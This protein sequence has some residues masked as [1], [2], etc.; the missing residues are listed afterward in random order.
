M[1]E[2]NKERE[3]FLSERKK[4]ENEWVALRR[5]QE[6][7]R[8]A[9]QAS[10]PLFWYRPRSDGGYEG[11]LHNDSIERCRKESG[12][13]VPL[14]AT[15]P[16]DHSEDACHMVT[17]A[18]AGALTDEQRAK[19]VQ[20]I[21]EMGTGLVTPLFAIVEAIERAVI[22]VQPAAPAH[23]LQRFAPSSRHEDGMA[24]DDQGDYVLFADVAAPAATQCGWQLVPVHPTKEMREAGAKINGQGWDFA[25]HTW[26]TMLLHAP[27]HPAATLAESRQGLSEREAFEAWVVG[28]GG[29]ITRAG[30]HDDRYAYPQTATL[31]HGWKAR[32]SSSRAEVSVKTMV[33]RFLGWKLPRDFSPDCGISFTPPTNPEW[34]PIGTSLFHADQ[35]RQMF[36]YVLAGQTAEPAIPDTEPMYK[37]LMESRLALLAV[38][39]G[40]SQKAIALIDAVL[41]AAPLA[42]AEAPK[43]EG[44]E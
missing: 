34:W 35:A 13:W 44:N 41:N 20:E 21:C 42:A 10:G 31:W 29:N 27:T 15:P 43:Q 11:P 5:L 33:D 7:A 32:A 36:E 4:L 2:Q 22:A 28:E 38:K 24:P 17:G 25:H 19:F 26:N 1:S 14:Y 8:A 23:A 39:S 30:G 9:P 40:A 18:A 6:Q 16:A 3:A 37:A 12:G